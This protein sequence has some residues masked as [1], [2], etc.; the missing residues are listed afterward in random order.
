MTHLRENYRM[1]QAMSLVLEAL[2][3][4]AIGAGVA[5]SPELTAGVLEYLST[6]DFAHSLLNIVGPTLDAAVA[7]GAV[8]IASLPVL[9]V[10]RR[11][12]SAISGDRR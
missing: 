2:I 12:A 9:D 6:I 11:I 4:V 5:S 7:G 8:S 1:L 3:S 10:T